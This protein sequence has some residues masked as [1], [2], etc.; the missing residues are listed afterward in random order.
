MQP[1]Q[2][3][4]GIR[5]ELWPWKY[6]ESE[7][8]E[9]NKHL[10]LE[11]AEKQLSSMRVFVTEEPD[12][13]FRKRI[14]SAIANNLYNSKESWSELIDR[15]MN[16]DDPIWEDYGETPIEIKNNCEHKIYGL[17]EILKLY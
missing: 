6:S 15:G 3:S 7:E 11:D 2:A 12:P 4:K 5:V 1:D 8:Y 16:V 14:E 10:V 17:P 9:K 13:R